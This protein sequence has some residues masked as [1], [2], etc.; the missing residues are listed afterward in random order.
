MLST[1]VIN[2]AA[3]AVAVAALLFCNN[4]AVATVVHEPGFTVIDH[5][6]LSG[7]SADFGGL[8]TDAS[9][10]VYVAGGYS[11]SV[12]VFD[13]TS[14]SIFGAAV[15]EGTLSTEVVGDTL[16]VGA[17]VFGRVYESSISSPGFSLV[18]SLPV[19]GGSDNHGIEDIALAPAGFGSF[20]GQLIVGTHSDGLWAMSTAG[21]ATPIAGGSFTSLEFDSNGNLF[22]VRHANSDLVTVSPSGTVSLF[23]SGFQS[24]GLAIHPS[25]DMY[26]ISSKSKAIFKITSA[27]AVSTFATDVS[28][29][30]GFFAQPIGFSPDFTTLWYTEDPDNLESISGFSSVVPVPEPSTLAIWSLFSLCGLAISWRRRGKA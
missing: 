26:A 1:K 24:E 4:P 25:G 6:N 23:A 10:N 22:A 14:H 12:A 5:G 11:T 9:G 8:T 29:D 28:A 18:G 15:P 30:F 2:C 17:Q 27:G 16:Y 21:V 3:A 20:G 19:A 13:G 7:R